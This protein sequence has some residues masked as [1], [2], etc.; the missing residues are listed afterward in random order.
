MVLMA[1]FFEGFSFDLAH[2]DRNSS[3]ET[4]GAFKAGEKCLITP[5]PGNF[6]QDLSLFHHEL[7]LKTRNRSVF[8][9]TSW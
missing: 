3:Q 6:I 8:T 9:I 2:S 5:K 7:H 1:L 4:K